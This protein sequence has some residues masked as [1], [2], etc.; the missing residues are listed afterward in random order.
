MRGRPT[1]YT[2]TLA[3]ELARHVAD[4]GSFRS[5]ALALGISPP[6]ITAWRALK[7]DFRC[8]ASAASLLR[9]ARLLDALREAGATQPKRSP[10]APDAATVLGW[11]RDAVYGQT[12]EVRREALDL[13]MA[14]IRPRAKVPFLPEH[15]A[16]QIDR[17]CADEWNQSGE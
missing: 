2:E 11:A 17:A 9:A 1:I 5:A 8:L 15:R 10:L 4:G 12:A 14:T 3:I 6:A 16:R 7:A 13:L